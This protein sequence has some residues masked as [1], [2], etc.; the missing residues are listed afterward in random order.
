MLSTIEKVI[1][2]K[3]VGIFA[4]TPDEVLADVAGLLEEV[5]YSNGEVIFNK[6]D[7]GTSMYMIISGKV[8]VHDDNYTINKLAN[9]RCSA[10]WHCSTLPPASPPS[11][12]WK[13]RISSDCVRKPFMNCWIIAAKWRGVLFGC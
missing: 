10:K 3:T 7:L 12:L 11:P 13:T 1:I 8:R 6:G 9:G 5:R 2:L 4:E